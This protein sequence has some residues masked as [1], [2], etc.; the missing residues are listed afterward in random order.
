[1]NKKYLKRTKLNKLF[2]KFVVFA[3]LSIFLTIVFIAICPKNA[4]AESLI[5]FE[6]TEIGDSPS[7]ISSSV[8]IILIFTV[9]S[10]AP[11]II[12]MMTSFTRI[13]IVLSFTRTAMGTQS[14]PSNQILIGL[15]LFMTFFIMSPVISEINTTAYKPLMAGEITQSEALTLGTKPLRDFMLKNTKSKDI[16]LFIELSGKDAPETLD[17]LS[18]TLV[19]P[20]FIISELSRAFQMGFFIFIP[21]IV[22]DMIVSSTLMSMG[23]MMLPPTMISLPFKILLFV[24]VDGWELTVRILISSFN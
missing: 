21:F 24:L 15:A 19:I 9:L 12:L 8:K 18:M 17:D 10:L 5:S 1:M 14:M 20:A 4:Q 22:I 11:S 13:I 16:N 3:C 23:M 7:E 6:D 2:K